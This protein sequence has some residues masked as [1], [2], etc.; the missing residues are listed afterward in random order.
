MG[1]TGLKI[2]C[3]YINKEFLMI[4]RNKFKASKKLKASNKLKSF[5]IYFAYPILACVGTPMPNPN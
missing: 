5:Q 1:Q 4:R 2:V 3:E